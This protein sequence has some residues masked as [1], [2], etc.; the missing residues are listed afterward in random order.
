ML[1]NNK[2]EFSPMQSCYFKDR[3]NTLDLKTFKFYAFNIYG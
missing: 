2:N 1:N 3:S